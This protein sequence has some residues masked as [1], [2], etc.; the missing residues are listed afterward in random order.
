MKFNNK[1][2]GLSYQTIQ[3]DLDLTYENRYT[4]LAIPDAYESLLLD[5]LRNDHSNFVRDDELGAAWRIFTPLLHKIDQQ[6]AAIKMTSYKYG[7]RGP[8]ELDDFVRKYGYDRSNAHYDW[9]VQS[10]LTKKE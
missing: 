9:P 7:S 8:D 6:D 4:D 3:T 1:M 2:P 10:V 5:V